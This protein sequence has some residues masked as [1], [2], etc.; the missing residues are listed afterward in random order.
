[1]LPVIAIV[2]VFGELLIHVSFTFPQPSLLNVLL[3]GTCPSLT[4]G[5]AIRKKARRTA[6]I[7]IFLCCG[8]KVT[9][10]TVTGLLMRIHKPY[11]KTQTVGPIRNVW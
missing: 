2:P 10:K 9:W 8:D 1:M 5:K 11:S 3:N 7:N 6:D 4:I